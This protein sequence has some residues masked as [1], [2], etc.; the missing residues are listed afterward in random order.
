MLALTLYYDGNCAL[1]RAQMARLRRLDKAG[2]LGFI[3]IAAPDFLP[4]ALGVSR[5]ALGTEIH[6][7]TADG[8]LL[9]GLDS[10]IAA[11][12]AV[13]RGWLVAPLRIG[14]LRPLFA[15]LYRALARN[16]YRLSA[17]ADGACKIAGR[18]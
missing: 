3:D 9:A 1:C 10:I 17:C 4:E 5:Q 8:R 11:H 14:V 2:R 15:A 12:A 6:A 16:R 18:P 7:R 13:G